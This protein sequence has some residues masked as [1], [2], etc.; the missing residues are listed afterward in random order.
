MNGLSLLYD[1][2]LKMVNVPYRWGGKFPGEGLDCSSLI[3]ILLH[4]YGL[5]IR[6]GTAQMLFDYFSRPENHLHD[7]AE[8]GSL[9]F[10]G[11]SRTEIDHVAMCLTP[12]RQI[13]A[14]GGGPEV[15][16]FESAARARA[17]V[18][19]TPIYTARRIGMFMPH[20]LEY[21]H[22]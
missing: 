1:L 21:R 11:D 5:S 17:Y 18:K 22:A 13:E 19:I 14:G 9:V 12:Y 15:T 8:L 10:Y 7:K 4:A 20:Y 3:N 2:A 6:N 16:S